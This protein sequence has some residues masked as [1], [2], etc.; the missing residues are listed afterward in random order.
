MATFRYDGEGTWLK[1][2]THIHSTNSDGGKTVDELARMYASEG[3]DFLFI[4]DHWKPY[5]GDGKAEFPLLVL[6]GVELHGK[7]A[8]GEFFH[9]ACLGT[10]H[11][12][13][14]DMGLEAGMEAARR[15]GGILILAH[16]HWTGNAPEDGLRLGVQG[17]EVYNHVC[18]WLNGKGWAGWHWDRMLET[19]PS[20][21]GLA[22]DDAH[23]RPEHPGWNGG[24][25]H[26]RTAARTQE[27]I[28]EAIRRGRFY[29]SRGPRIH[30]LSM[31]GGTVRLHCSPVQRIRLVGWRWKGQRVA[32][33]GGGDLTEA[34]FE[35]PGDDPY[36]RLEIEDA[37]GARAWTNTLLVP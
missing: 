34:S 14:E 29:C 35:I 19:D 16:P 33:S 18:E 21:I 6:D 32:A 20:L 28:L 27:S 37:H 13:S 22:V 15:Q 3:Y 8:R 10:F 30:S 1:G 12:I 17:V 24:W 31:E 2:N 5:V 9:I 11:G 36:V 26:V 23:I 7:D 4:T 25:I